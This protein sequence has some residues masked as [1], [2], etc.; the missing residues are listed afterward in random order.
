MLAESQTDSGRITAL[1][2]VYIAIVVPASLTIL[3]KPV[4]SASPL[5]HSAFGFVTA[6]VS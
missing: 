3:T 1:S 6:T 4:P 2:K 5:Q